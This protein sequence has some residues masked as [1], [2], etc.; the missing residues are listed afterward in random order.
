MIDK[1]KQKRIV[2]EYMKKW[3]KNFELFSKHIDDFK[4]PRLRI[5]PNLSQRE[6]KRLWKELVKEVKKEIQKQQ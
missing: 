6:F 4:I 1:E 2:K 5:A 3:G